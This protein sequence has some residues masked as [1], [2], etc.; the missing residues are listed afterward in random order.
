MKKVFL[1]LFLCAGLINANE[2][3]FVKKKPKLIE[4]KKEVLKEVPLKSSDK[5]FKYKESDFNKNKNFNESDYNKMNKPGD[6]F[7][8]SDYSNMN[9]K[10][11]KESD[12]NYLKPN[13]DLK[14]K[15]EQSFNNIKNFFGED[16]ANKEKMKEDSFTGG[17]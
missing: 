10:E 15:Q 16:Y 6:K 8:K 13:E 1:C 4:T 9:K 5:D 12:F 17:D 7:N 11:Y 3:E 2:N 14:K